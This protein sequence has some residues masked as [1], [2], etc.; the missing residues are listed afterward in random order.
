[1][2]SPYGALSSQ[3]FFLMVFPPP[4]TPS[5][6][7]LFLDSAPDYHTSLLPPLL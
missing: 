3:Y 4:D 6:L 2:L 1:M 7:L 5:S